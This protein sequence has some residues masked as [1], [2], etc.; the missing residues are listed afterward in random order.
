PTTQADSSS[1]RSSYSSNTYSNPSSAD[2]ELTSERE[3]DV[4]FEKMLTRRGIH[5][6]S[7]RATMTAF[8]IDKKR[9]MLSQDVHAASSPAPTP[10]TA[11]NSLQPSKRSRSIP[12]DLKEVDRGSPDYYILKFKEP[13]MKN[14]NP[15]LI[16]HLAVSLRTMPL[17]WVRQFIDSRGLQAM[18]DALGIINR[19]AHKTDA[20]LQM[21]TEILKCFKS[22]LNNRWGARD[23]ITNPQCIFNA[24]F[25]IVSSSMVTRKLVC[26]VMAFLC[27]CEVPTGQD[28]VLRAMDQV[29]EA[30]KEM[31]R[32]DAWLNIWEA[33]LDGRG[34][35]GSMVGASGE[36]KKNGIQSAPDGQL[37]D[38]A[39]SNMMLVNAIIQVVDD[40]ELRIHVRNQLNVC[41]LQRIIEKIK[42]FSNDHIHRHIQGYKSLAES[43]TDD[44]MEI[45]NDQVLNDL[46]DPRDVFECIL[47]SVE[48][49][50]G[51][52]FFLS[53][54]QH[55]LFVKDEG[56]VRTR[57][58][59]VLDSFV[60]QIVLDNKGLSEDF[61]SSYGMSVRYLIDKF[62][63]Q[64]QLSTALE[65][66]RETRQ[67]YEQTLEAK[68][69][70]ER[71]INERGD[72]MVSKL[73]EKAA[74]L[75][76]LLRISRHT[77]A[78]L[79]DKLQ[80]LQRSYE[81]NLA[82]MEQ[83]LK[84]V[85]NAKMSTDFLVDIVNQSDACTAEKKETLLRAYERI[86]AQER[87]EGVSKRTKNS[88]LTPLPLNIP[89]DAP[90]ATGL[91]A[92]FKAE[93]AQQFG[94]SNR[95]SGF[96]V[97]GTAPKLRASRRAPIM[98]DKLDA[99]KEA[100]SRRSSN[101]ST[102]RISTG[103]S[104]TDDDYEEISSGLAAAL[105][106]RM[107][108]LSAKYAERGADSDASDRFSMEEQPVE[109]NSIHVETSP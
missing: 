30:R 84:D 90:L 106:A 29:R 85:A 16:A 1:W 71:D 27:Y 56:E 46:T 87:L 62:A 61:T 101:G 50:R 81:Q 23:V 36:F 34:R 6:P 89:D 48:G 82:A 41:G 19:K 104:S 64:D 51:Y 38:Y 40:L 14:V 20:E 76:D 52:E 10:V 37:S 13:D 11:P 59:Q 26:E 91:S 45:Y 92:S 57:Y 58:Y 70:L 2:S 33:T 72:G 28:L 4:M 77:I 99:I 47:A 79:Q 54:L 86:E 12:T 97:P 108:K 93:L 103:E 35:L 74:S 24:I 42:T 15:R 49:T 78:T 9:L 94:S 18:T 39:L 98:F 96:I 31:G 83:K 53:A 80:D 65:E 107:L 88:I 60:S 100:E 21:E 7:T 25:S 69:A 68:N 5:D 109:D 22:L 73:K 95:L 105:K 102:K 55:L 3:V 66:V 8:S 17:S 67:L 32:F 75:E 44:M 63:E 43:D